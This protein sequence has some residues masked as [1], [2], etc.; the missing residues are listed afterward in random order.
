MDE[1]EKKQFNVWL[2]REP[3]KTNSKG[4]KKNYNVSSTLL[5]CILQTKPT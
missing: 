4:K 2:A 3:L 1:L 5:V